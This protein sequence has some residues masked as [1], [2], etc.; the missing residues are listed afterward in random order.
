MSDK[1]TLKSNFLTANIDRAIVMT[2]YDLRGF[3]HPLGVRL[4]NGSPK[5]L[6]A[7]TGNFVAFAAGVSKEGGPTD[8]GHVDFFNSSY[9]DYLAMCQ[10]LAADCDLSQREAIRLIVKEILH[11]HSEMTAAVA[12]GN[13]EASPYLQPLSKDNRWGKAVLAL[14]EAFKETPAEQEEK[15]AA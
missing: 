15:R 12:A 10:R 6:D 7:A 2:Q 5:Y 1:Q 13:T 3:A 4:K 9:D 14:M 8:A 11:Q